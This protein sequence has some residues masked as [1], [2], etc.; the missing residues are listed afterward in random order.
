M[1]A[2]AS[3][4]RTRL[5]YMLLLLV[6]MWLVAACTLSSSGGS[7]DAVPVISGLP[8]VNLASPLPN[9]TYLEGITVNVQATIANAGPD[10]ARVDVAVDGA[11]V[12]SAE[13]PNPGGAVTFSVTFS[14]AA[15]GAGQHSISV[16][17]F[18]GDGTSSAPATVNVTVVDQSAPAQQPTT[19]PTTNSG[20]QSTQAPAV[21]T[22]PPTNPPA[23]QPTARPSSTPTPSPTSNVPM[24]RLL[25]GANV[26]AGPSTLFNPPI[27]SIA[28]NDETEVLAVSPDNTWYKVR[29]YNGE[30]WI[31]ANLLSISGDVSR[32]PVDAGPPLP[33]TPTPTPIPPTPVPPSNINLFVANLLVNP[34]PLVCGSTANLEITVSNN[35]SEA[36][37]GGKIS[38]QAIL[39]ST[40]AVLESTVT[41][42]PDLAP[43]Q[44][45]TAGAALTVGT[46]F[47]ELQRIT[48]R[49]DSDNVVRENDEND[50][51]AST[52]Y[53]LAKGGC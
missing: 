22:Q 42:F 27:G 13:A 19:A 53:I 36:S 11:V 6:A 43:G 5:R 17:A 25:A 14:W 26:R 40:G 32:V 50:N 8:V 38:V 30:G 49:V 2:S 15:S 24:A 47:D 3:G 39:V 9:A 41:V 51:T 46:N 23:Q 7:G 21:N 44:S 52:D 4:S 16:I 35:G 31:F 10:I 28:A 29:Y 12:G 37:S 1:V 20:A 45:H 33:P 48:A 34:H 18:R